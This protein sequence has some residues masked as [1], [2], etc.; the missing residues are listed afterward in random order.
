MRI[1]KVFLVI[2]SLLL[3]V[4]LAACK[5]EATPTEEA[6]PVEE[7]AVVMEPVTFQVFYP[8]AMD[9][10]IA[11]ILNGYIEAFQAEYP[12]ITV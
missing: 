9:A 11:A 8:V 3:I 12:H 7:E 1:T 6:A 4:S 5:P 10:P 2:L